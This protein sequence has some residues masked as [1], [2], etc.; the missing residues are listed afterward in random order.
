MADTN[1]PLTA[2]DGHDDLPRTFRREHEARRREA[3]ERRAKEDSA[4]PA[5]DTVYPGAQDT[6]YAGDYTE[7]TFPA[8]VRKFDVPFV[9]LMFFFLKAVLAAIPALIVLGALIWS[10]GELLQM[11]FP[12]LIKMQ[13]F[14]HF[15]K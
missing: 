5:A 8:S 6:H 4:I 13:I 14:I 11:F 10:A 12:D 9:S 2:E 1:Y 7:D 3:E 15:P